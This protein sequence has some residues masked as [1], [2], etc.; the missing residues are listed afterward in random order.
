[1]AAFPKV[2]VHCLSSTAGSKRRR[3]RSN[4][5]L[6]KVASNVRLETYPETKIKP[7]DIAKYSLVEL[8]DAPEQWLVQTKDMSQPGHIYCKIKAGVPNRFQWSAQSRK[9]LQSTI[10]VTVSTPIPERLGSKYHILGGDKVLIQDR[11]IQDVQRHKVISTRNLKTLTIDAPSGIS[12]WIKNHGS[13][14]Q[15]C[16]T[17]RRSMGF[18]TLAPGQSR[19]VS[20]SKE[21][22]VQRMLFTGLSQRD[23]VLAISIDDGEIK[24]T[25]TVHEGLTEMNRILE[26]P[27]TNRPVAYPQRHPTDRQGILEARSTVL[28]QDLSNDTHTITLKNIGNAELHF[29]VHIETDHRQSNETDQAQWSFSEVLE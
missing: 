10:E 8:D 18:W 26:M 13:P 23:G 29:R 28:K 17:P 12:A 21:K 6:V 2:C 7:S 24:S 1:M 16:D 14:N 5:Q 4:D 27:R 9:A 19:V 11:L 22:A 20:F 25:Q 15:A 3:T